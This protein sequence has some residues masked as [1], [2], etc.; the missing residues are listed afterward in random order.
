ML[1]IK[2]KGYLADKFREIDKK[3]VDAL[4]ENIHWALIHGTDEEARKALGDIRARERIQRITLLGE[5][6]LGYIGDC[7]AILKSSRMERR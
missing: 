5:A 6:A 1:K 2:I 3:Q 4:P 7:R